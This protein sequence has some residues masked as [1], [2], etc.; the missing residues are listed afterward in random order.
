MREESFTRSRMSSP[1]RRDFIRGGSA[2][3]LSA[4]ATGL[5]GCGAADKGVW[6]GLGVAADKNPERQ[7]FNGVSAKSGEI[8]PFAFKALE[9]NGR[10]IHYVDEGS[11][12][13][14][15]L[16]HGQGNWSYHFRGVIARLKGRARVVCHD[17][18]GGGLSD[19][20]AFHRQYTIEN[21]ISTLYGVIKALDLRGITFYA[22]DWGGPISFA[23]A[24]A[25]P[26]NMRGLVIGNTWAWSEHVPS[27]KSIRWRTRLSPVVRP[28]ASRMTPAR[29]AIPTPQPGGDWDTPEARD[30]AD[31]PSRYSE[32][33][34]TR[35]SGFNR[36]TQNSPDHPLDYLR[37][38]ARTF[39][40]IEAGLPKLQ[41]LPV[42]VMAPDDA[43][44]PPAG[45]EHWR[46]LFPK[47][48]PLIPIKNHS[49][50]AQGSEP[51]S[52]IIAAA[53]GDVLDEAARMDAQGGAR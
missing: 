22:M 5:V 53:I 37:R 10:R 50:I 49:H 16:V 44:F 31:Y 38:T 9:I 39:A 8:Y 48:P 6:A 36:S 15:M 43:V 20:P 28:L 24:T 26:E 27:L 2:L 40:Q 47:A 52:D 29:A 7:L 30:V 17:H 3:G 14:V 21:H 41:H 13:T 23:Y 11:G 42:R 34:E 4:A 46:E 18:F 19:K 1:S 45:Q 25:H 33:T 35:S 12:P 51:G 32:L